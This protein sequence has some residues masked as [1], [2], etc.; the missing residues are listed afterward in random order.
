MLLGVVLQTISVNFRMFVAA[1]FFLGF[2]VAIAHSCSPL[3]ITELAHPQHRAIFTT[4]YNTTWYFGSIIAAW[5]TFGTN[6]INSNW[7]WRAPTIVQAFPSLLQLTF[8]WFVP[9]SPRWYLAK[10][11]DELAL[12]VLADV[13]AN[14]NKDDELVQLELTEIRDTIRME[15]EFESNGWKELIRTRGN[16]HR[17]LILVTAG[18]FSQWSGNGLVSY[19]IH[20]VL[21]DIGYTSVVTQDLING[22]LQIF[23]FAVALT[24][25]FFVD[26]IGR[27]LLFLVSTGGMLVAFIVWTICSSRYAMDG[28]SAAA[29]AVI[30]MIFIYYFFYNL[31]WSGLLIGYTAEILPYKIRAKGLTVMFL[32]VDLALF[33]NQYINPIALDALGWKYYIFYCCWLGVELATVYFFYIETRNTPLEEIV[34]HFDGEQAVLGGGAATEKGLHLA[35]EAGFDDTVRMTTEK[36]AAVEVE[37]VRRVNTSSSVEP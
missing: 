5:L 10:G 28:S 31:A 16:R 11:R 1:R 8:V 33:F 7:Q 4:I 26:I 34:K 6:H 29:K 3:L 14:G 24:M 37:G 25:C 15:Q 30:G 19:Y 18:F 21:N 35:S 17:L 2:G 22:V 32:C 13:H 9:E 12:K 20:K 23:N 27:R 36:Q